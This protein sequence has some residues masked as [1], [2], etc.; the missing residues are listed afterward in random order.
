MKF[1]TIFLVAMIA[2]MAMYAAAQQAGDT[3][4]AARDVQPGRL[5]EPN[6]DSIQGTANTLADPCRAATNYF[7]WF[8]ENGRSGIAHPTH[9]ADWPTYVTWF[10]L[11]LT[12]FIAYFHIDHVTRPTLTILIPGSGSCVKKTEPQVENTSKTDAEGA[13]VLRLVID[14][15]AYHCDVA[16]VG[17]YSG[18]RVWYFPGTSKDM[19]GH[20]DL[21]SRI[22]EILCSE[23][24]PPEKEI[25]L[26]SCIQYRRFYPHRVTWPRLLRGRMYFK[27]Y[28]SPIQR[29]QLRHARCWVLVP[30]FS[31]P[32][33]PYDVD[34]CLFKR[35]PE[36]KT[37]V[38]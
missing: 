31:N 27:I 7:T 17:A 16:G 15:I 30:D 36:S 24:I 25:Y 2:C 20:I 18:K 1:S 26:E 3:L 33:R 35:K 14:G 19:R 12:A 9:T 6:A 23:T 10:F 5:I 32:Q 28:R 29:W 22:R 21:E 8:E 34:P 11:A 13:V 38:S 37:V 4:F